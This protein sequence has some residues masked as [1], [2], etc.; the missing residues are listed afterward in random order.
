MSIKPLGRDFHGLVSPLAPDL[1]EGQLHYCFN[2]EEKDVGGRRERS[3]ESWD[4]ATACDGHS[5]RVPGP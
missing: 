1:A 3:S 2:A 5:G 4:P